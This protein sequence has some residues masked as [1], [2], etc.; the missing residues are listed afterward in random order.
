M[1]QKRSLV[2]S[3]SLLNHYAHHTVKQLLSRFCRGGD[4]AVFSGYLSQNEYF[5]DS[6][7]S[8]SATTRSHV[9]MDARWRRPFPGFQAPSAFSRLACALA[10]IVLVLCFPLAVVSPPVST[11]SRYILKG[12]RTETVL[13]CPFIVRDSN[14]V[15]V[16]IA[17]HFADPRNLAS[18]TQAGTFE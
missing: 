3:R 2:F 9:I 14:P 12:Y 11:N 8:C 1:H 6:S 5:V 7:C 15:S 13:Q 10:A 18:S 17:L 4:P 16:L